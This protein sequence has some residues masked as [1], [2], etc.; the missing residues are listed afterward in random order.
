MPW[1]DGPYRGHDDKH[2]IRPGYSSDH[3]AAYML[4]EIAVRIVS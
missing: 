3:G 1:L 2:H 4:W